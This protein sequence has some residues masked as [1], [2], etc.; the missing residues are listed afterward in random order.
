MTAKA[1]NKRVALVTGASA[2]LGKAFAVCCAP[3]LATV[4]PTTVSSARLPRAGHRRTAQAP[5]VTEKVVCN[6]L[7]AGWRREPRA[8]PGPVS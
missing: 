6:C 4:A 1:A 3:R 5:Q 7:P 2:G 8:A